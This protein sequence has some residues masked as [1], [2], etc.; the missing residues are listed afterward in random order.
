MSDQVPTAEFAFELKVACD[1]PTPLGQRG[2]GQLLMIPITGGTIDGPLLQGEVLPGGADWAVMREG[3]LFT[4]DARYAIR[5][6]DGTV[7]QVFN[8]VTNRI[9]RSGESVQV[10]ITSP[11]F[12]APDGPHG[13]LNE[14]VFVGTLLA[15]P[16]GLSG[17]VTVRVYR[18]R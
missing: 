10:M 5:A 18:M 8:G 9:D 17:G 14:G 3:G 7:I 12:I 16:A 11:H 4:V 15:D 6:T 13:W 1:Q 2:D